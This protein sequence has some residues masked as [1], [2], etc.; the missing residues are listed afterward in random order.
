[1][2]VI[3]Q[4]NI[5]QNA[6]SKKL[7][8]FFLENRSEVK[9][10]FARPGPALNS[11]PSVSCTGQTSFS[12]SQSRRGT[13]EFL[14]P[15]PPK[16]PLRPTSPRRLLSALPDRRPGRRRHAP[17]DAPLPP[18]R[19]FPRSRPPTRLPCAA[20]P[21]SPAT[22]WPGG[23]GEPGERTRAPIW[24]DRLGSGLH[25]GPSESGNAVPII[26]WGTLQGQSKV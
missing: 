16:V 1:M 14:N 22:T 4:Q 11:P 25:D 10:L 8:Y 5:L 12:K 9:W 20:L 21:W 3:R 23:R 15:A 17:P 26:H 24:T 18:C 19:S 6:R 2:L 13:I 7:I